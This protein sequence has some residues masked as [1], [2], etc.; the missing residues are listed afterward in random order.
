MQRISRLFDLDHILLLR[1]VVTATAKDH[2]FLC[3]YTWYITP[4][5]PQ[6]FNHL[7]YVLLLPGLGQR[8]DDLHDVPV[9]QTA[10]CALSCLQSLKLKKVGMN[11]EGVGVLC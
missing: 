7:R 4:L 5:V 9:H 10:V 6:T 8:G 1:T 11:L 3:V 2:M